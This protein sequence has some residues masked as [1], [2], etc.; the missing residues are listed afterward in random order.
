M[1]IVHQIKFIY[2]FLRQLSKYISHIKELLR[3]RL[4]LYTILQGDQ[5]TQVLVAFLQV[6]FAVYV[7][8]VHCGVHILLT[9]GCTWVHPCSYNEPQDR[10]TLA[11]CITRMASHQS[12]RHVIALL[13][14]PLV[15]VFAVPLVVKLSLFVMCG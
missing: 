5:F 4:K 10:S 6:V 2:L 1:F 3:G 15:K 8:E 14:T 12:N 13:Y 9:E 11:A 7:F